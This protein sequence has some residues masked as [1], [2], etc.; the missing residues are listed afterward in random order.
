MLIFLQFSAG[1]FYDPARRA[2]TPLL[3]PKAQLPLATTLDTY[4]WSIVGAFGASLGGLVVSKA[5]TGACFLLDT[6]T[7]LAAAW[8]AWQ[9]Q[10]CTVR[11]QMFGHLS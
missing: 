1:A 9:L 7:Y 6:C 4:A 10:V 11:Q 2:I 8:C 3:V 5:G